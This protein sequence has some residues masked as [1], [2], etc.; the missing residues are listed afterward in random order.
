M[1]S[2][3]ADILCLIHFL[4]FSILTISAWFGKMSA[5]RRLSYYLCC[6][7]EIRDIC[8]L[9]NWWYML[10]PGFCW[11][12]RFFT[13]GFGWY[14]RWSLLLQGIMTFK[15]NETS[16]QTLHTWTF[17]SMTNEAPFSEL[18][19]SCKDWAPGP[20]YQLLANLKKNAGRRKRF[21]FDLRN[22]T[23][24]GRLKDIG[25]CHW[26]GMTSLSTMHT[27]VGIENHRRGWLRNSHGAIYSR[28]VQLLN[29]TYTGS[30]ISFSPISPTELH[31]TV[32]F[33]RVIFLRSHCHV[34][35][36]PRKLHRVTV[37]I[38]SISRFVG[39]PAFQAPWIKSS[40]F[41]FR[42]GNSVLVFKC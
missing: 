27:K 29:S 14:H 32:R 20:G 26:W 36:F 23:S 22:C 33:Y 5:G 42:I 8:L 28:P 41:L 16:N 34:F 24:Q 3:T 1:L 7:C 12:R 15:E 21:S 10:I 18:S 37:R 25:V 4:S 35:L 19:M 13:A 30:P 39:R 6:Q 40:D 11:T 9:G 2:K 31:R 17:F 38:Y